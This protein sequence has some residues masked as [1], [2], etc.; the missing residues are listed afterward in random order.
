MAITFQ[1]NLE[2]TNVLGTKGPYSSN[3]PQGSYFKFTRSTWFPDFLRDNHYLRHGNLLV[4]G[5]TYVN[6][7]NVGFGTAEQALYLLNNFTF[8]H[9]SNGPYCFLNYVSGN[10]E[11]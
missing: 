5:P 1:V 2:T 10:A 9:G 3:D 11:S 6:D 4:V 7:V 8:G